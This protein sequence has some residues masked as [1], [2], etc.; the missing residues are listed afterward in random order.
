MEKILYDVYDGYEVFIKY[1]VIGQD[2]KG[3]SNVF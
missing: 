1:Y 2:L 3:R